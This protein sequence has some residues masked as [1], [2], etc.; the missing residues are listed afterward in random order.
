MTS[1]H[2][3]WVPHL[4]GDV[5]E[6]THYYCH[7]WDALRLGFACDVP[8]RHMTHRSDGDQEERLDARRMPG[9]DPIIEHFAETSLSTGANERV[10]AV[11]E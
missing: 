1:H 2:G 10:G 9:R 5:S 6:R 7:G 4:L 11:G 8:D 3:P